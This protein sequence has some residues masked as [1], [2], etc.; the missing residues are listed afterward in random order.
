MDGDGVQDE[1]VAGESDGNTAL[2][3]DIDGTYNGYFVAFTS[4]SGVNVACGNIDGDVEEEIIIGKASGGNQV[5]MF[6]PDGTYIRYFTV[7]TTGSGVNL[8]GG[9]I[10]GDGLGEVIVG[11]KTGG[12]ELTVFEGDGTYISYFTALTIGDG[13]TPATLDIDDDGIDE[14]IVGKESGGNEVMLFE[15]DGN[16]IRI[17]NGLA[18][19]NGSNV[20]AGMVAASQQGGGQ[21]DDLITKAENDGEVKVIVSLD[22]DFIPEGYFSTTQES[23]DQRAHIEAMQDS[24]LNNIV[25]GNVGSVKKFGNMI[26]HMAM[27]VD[28]VALQEVISDSQIV[29]IVEDEAVPLTLS[30]SIPIINADDVWSRGYSG[31]GQTVAILDTGVDSSHS[32]LAGKVVEEACYSTNNGIFNSTT[33]CPNGMEEQTG[34]GAGINCSL[35]VN[36]CDHG[37]HVAGIAAGNGASFLGV[38]KDADIISIQVFSEFDNVGFCG[39]QNPCALSYVSDQIDGLTRVYDLRLTYNI[40]SVNMSLGG[41]GI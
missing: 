9:D 30:G 39:T 13:R 29:N 16:L 5:I 23:E 1:I 41:G 27:S 12:N 8:A 31:V 11:K 37:T 38:A 22:M 3:F 40:A 6:E 36:G 32:F 2:F 14:I 20:A 18:G 15:A 17:F 35:S 7:F 21:Y 28:S 25:S 10:D 24:V 33:V 34:P 19:T 26:P 4:G